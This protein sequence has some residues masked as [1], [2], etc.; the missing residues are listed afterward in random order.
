MLLGENVATACAFVGC[1]VARGVECVSGQA[2]ITFAQCTAIMGHGLSQN[3]QLD[4]IIVLV[5][6]LRIERRREGYRG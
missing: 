2:S 3:A 5:C 1:R 4:S 6:A